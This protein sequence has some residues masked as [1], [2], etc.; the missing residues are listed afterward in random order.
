MNAAATRQDVQTALDRAKNSILGSV[1]SRNDAQTILN[2]LR[3]GL[4]QDIQAMNS[5]TMSGMKLAHA[6][7]DHLIQRVS[8]LQQ[9]VARLSEQQAQLLAVLQQI[10]QPSS[11]NSPIYR[12]V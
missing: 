12:R 11:T 1:V 2:Q 7:H 9:Q 10:I 3:R 6:Q 5:Q 4:I 8:A